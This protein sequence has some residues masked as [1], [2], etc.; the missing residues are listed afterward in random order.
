MYGFS[1]CKKC[2][3]NAALLQSYLRQNHMVTKP[4]ELL[5]TIKV[6]GMPHIIK[7]A[8]PQTPSS[9][10][11]PNSDDASTTDNASGSA[12]LAPDPP[13]PTPLKEEKMPAE[14]T[15]DLE[16][17]CK[18]TPL[19]L[20]AD[21][22]GCCFIS[23]MSSSVEARFLAAMHVWSPVSMTT[24]R[25]FLYSHTLRPGHNHLSTFIV[26]H[27]TNHLTFILLKQAYDIACNTKTNVGIITHN[28]KLFFFIIVCTLVFLCDLVCSSSF[29]LSSAI[30][31]R[32]EGYYISRSSFLFSHSVAIFV[33]S[34]FRLSPVSC[35][36]PQTRRRK[37]SGHRNGKQDEWIS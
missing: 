4:F 16:L 5:N 10:G 34:S 33:E 27:A 8:N 31:L 32:S 2:F 17:T 6:G 22:F 12:W 21:S 30:V 35:S 29:V 25:L 11:K 36:V 3:N 18:T 7:G 15:P 26:A 37:K 19:H 1:H 13:S 28:S 23:V 14:K 24:T 20:P 9:V